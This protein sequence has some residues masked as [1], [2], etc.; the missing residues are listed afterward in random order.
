MTRATRVESLVDLLDRH[1]A[2]VGPERCGFGPD[3]YADRELD[4]P[5][6]Y[7]LYLRGLVS[8]H[9]ATGRSS[10]LAACRTPRT[11]LLG[12]R[13]GRAG[14]LAFAW[15][16]RPAAEPYAITTALAGRALA[17]LLR[18]DGDD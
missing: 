1:L 18:A 17:S 4:H 5:A 3:E 10:D 12:L 7:A 9:S 14:G 2:A 13:R 8:L 16:G 11:R 6:A 15:R